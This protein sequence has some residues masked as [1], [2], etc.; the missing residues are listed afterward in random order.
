MMSALAGP[1][2]RAFQRAESASVLL[3]IWGTHV[4]PVF[5][6]NIQVTETAHLP[7]LAPYRADATLTFQVLEGQ[8][9]FMMVEKARMAVQ[10]A[11]NFTKT[12]GSSIG[13]LLG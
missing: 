7:N 12:V 10:A 8:N 11:M 2:P 13:G 3:F 1:P 5:L 9:P 6:T 4:L